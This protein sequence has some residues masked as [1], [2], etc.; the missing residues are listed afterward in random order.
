MIKTPNFGNLL[1]SLFLWALLL[2]V[3]LVIGSFAMPFAIFRMRKAVHFLAR[4][5]GR[6][7]A[8]CA[9][10]KIVIKNKEKLY[11]GGP[12]IY[13]A[14]HQSMFD[15]PVFYSMLDSEFRWMAKSSLFKI[16]IVGWGMTGAG[17]I[18][19]ERGDRKKAMESLFHAADRI[20]GGASVII[21]PEGTRSENP[22]EGMLPFKKGGFI[23]AKK[24][25]V[26]IQP[27]TIWGAHHIM[28]AKQKVWVQRIY[29]GL[30][31]AEVH[32]AIP[33][34]AY[35]NMD[36]EALAAHVRTIIEGPMKQM[37][38]TLDENEKKR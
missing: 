21:F 23:L 33:A 29:P 35:A 9:G 26:T 38:N 6:A 12:V 7:L 19:V 1:F 30:V 16:P 11:R 18:P 13:L 34:E 15:I 5:W 22:H 20:A 27:I 24:A 31:Q 37:S 2:S 32:D 17:Y 25:N 10:I 4:L 28:P 36:A 14:N 8:F 3:T